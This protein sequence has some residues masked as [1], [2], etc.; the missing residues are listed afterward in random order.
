MLTPQTENRACNV[1]ETPGHVSNPCLDGAH[2]P[3]PQRK[4]GNSTF[5]RFT[6]FRSGSSLLVERCRLRRQRKRAPRFAGVFLPRVRMWRRGRRRGNAPS[7]S[8]ASGDTEVPMWLGTSSLA[9][10]S[11]RF[12][13]R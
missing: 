11:K 1:D 5:P 4:G 13:Y 6:T 2:A 3:V 12:K 9:S 7:Y 8:G 10:L